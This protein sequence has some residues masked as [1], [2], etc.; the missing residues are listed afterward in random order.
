MARISIFLMTITG[1]LTGLTPRQADGQTIPSPYRYFENKQEAGVFAGILGPGT[2]RFGFGPKSGSAVGA[3]YGLQLGGPFGL[4]GTFTYQP[5]TRDIVD[6]TRAEGERV[7]GEA[8]AEMLS[9]DARLRFSLTGDRTWRGLNPFVFMGGGITWD[10][11]GET[12]A[13]AVILPQDRFEFGAKFVALLGGG[14]RWVLT[15]RVLI[16]ADFVITMN[17]LKTPQGY[18]DPER[19]L[20]GVGEKEWVSGPGFSIGAAFHF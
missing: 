20:R 11:A 2:G 16:R 7:V 6:P 4:E 14:M 19:A 10:I 9:F 17:Q 12:E 3:R 15:E 13:D 1:L 18:L 5:T 8:D